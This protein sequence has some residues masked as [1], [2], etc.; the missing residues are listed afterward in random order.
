MVRDAG[1]YD[2]AAQKEKEKSWTVT[3]APVKI[4]MISNNEE[5]V[6]VLLESELSDQLIED[7]PIIG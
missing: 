4:M 2:L 7:L 1:K 5:I 6:G 3:W